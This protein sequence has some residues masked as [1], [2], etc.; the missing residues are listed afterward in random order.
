MFP[1]TGK[2]LI[3]FGLVMVAL[4]VL[5]LSA[6]KIP[7]VGRLPGD[8]HIQKKGWEFHFPL[9]T[10]I[11]ISIVLSIIFILFGS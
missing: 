1:H 7:F 6:E 3:I 5:L 2:L 9:T 4:G 11:L 8:I 10:S